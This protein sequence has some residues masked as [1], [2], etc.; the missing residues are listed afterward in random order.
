MHR[1]LKP[2]DVFIKCSVGAVPAV[3]GTEYLSMLLIRK[4]GKLGT[5]KYRHHIGWHPLIRKKTSMEDM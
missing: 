3:D 2:L 1:A 4:F 5:E